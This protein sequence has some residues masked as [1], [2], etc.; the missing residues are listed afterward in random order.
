MDNLPVHMRIT[1]LT[2]TNED[3]DAR[4]TTIGE[5]SGVWGKISNIGE[6]LC[7]AE[8]I[9]QSLGGDGQ[10]NVNLGMEVQEGLQKHASAFLYEESPLDVGV[11]AGLA[12]VSILRTAPSTSGWTTADVYSNAV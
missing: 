4:R 12:I 5:L 11:C 1:S 2:P 9:A 8:M 3:V 6:I 7:K 10:P